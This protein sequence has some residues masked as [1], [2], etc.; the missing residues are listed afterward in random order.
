MCEL[1]SLAGEVLHKFFFFLFYFIGAV[2]H[3]LHLLIVLWV[4]PQIHRHIRG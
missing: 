2:M 1:F 3:I 4:S